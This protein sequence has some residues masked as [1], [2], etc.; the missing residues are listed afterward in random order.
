MIHHKE[1]KNH[2]KKQKINEIKSI[3]DKVF[4]QSHIFYPKD[5][6]GKPAG[7]GVA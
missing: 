1:R 3:I 6:G 7:R 4:F 5:S 2:T